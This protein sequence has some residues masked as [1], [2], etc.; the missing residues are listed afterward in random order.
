MLKFSRNKIISILK[1]NE[2]ILNV[3]G[4][5]EDVIY[6]LEADMKVNVSSKKIL[7][8]KGKWNRYTTPEC[9]KA[10]NYLQDIVGFNTGEKYIARQ[11]QKTIG[12]K[13]C[14]HFA[15][16]M[17]DCCYSVNEAIKILKW[18]EAKQKNPELT[19]EMYLDGTDSIIP[20]DNSPDREKKKKNHQP[21]P[22][23]KAEISIK[24][25]NQ[26]QKEKKDFKGGM[27]I[28]LHV[29][30]FPASPCSSVSE[31]D[32]IKEAKKIGLDGICLTDHNYEW[33]RDKIEDLSQKHGFLVLNGNEITTDQGHILVFGLNKPLKKKGII[34]LE[35]LR[36]KV[37]QS[38]G[39]MIVSHPFRGFLT[40]GV[41]KLGLSVEKAVDRKI[42]KYVDALE[43]MN[44]K[45]TKDENNFA[46]KVAD[47]LNISVTGGSDAHSKEEV[48][49][50]A[51]RF[52]GIIKE[53]K[54]LL[55]ILRNGE[56]MPVSYRK[57]QNL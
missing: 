14:G 26:N 22:S 24:N 29:H 17:I 31:D 53:E 56:Y 27:I 8:V 42:F 9:P 18:E 49:L 35:D 41:G 13:A 6:G 44:G 33:T 50:H 37:T 57:L 43:I 47:K 12:R 3:H 15:N 55:E 4:V 23:V 11:I 30:S 34:K 51:T 40:F 7:S 45:V 28:D 19:F 39:F 16:L 48:G 52:N 10:L 20:Q 5:L 21:L 46:K 1:V 32:L 2:D 36:E 38:G 54:D 25:N